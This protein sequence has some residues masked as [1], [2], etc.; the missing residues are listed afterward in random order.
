MLTSVAAAC[1]RSSWCF[2]IAS[3]LRRG[4]CCSSS[5]SRGSSP[6][7]PQSA[8]SGSRSAVAAKMSSAAAALDPSSD[9]PPPFFRVA[10]VGGG[11]AGAA[12]ASTIAAAAGANSRVTLF[13]GGR[14]SSRPLLRKALEGVAENPL[15]DHGCQFV[16]DDGSDAR[17][18]ALLREHATEWSGEEELEGGG[19]RFVSLDFETGRVRAK[20]EE[21]ARDGDGDGDFFGVLSKGSRVWVGS[22]T[23]DAIPKRLVGDS[24]SKK[25]IDVRVGWKVTAVAR[26]GAGGGEWRVSARPPP[27]PPPGQEGAAAGSAGAAP[28]DEAGPLLFDAVVLSDASAMRAGSASAV[29][30]ELSSSEG[31]GAAGGGGGGGGALPSSPSSAPLEALARSRRAPLFSVAALLPNPLPRDSIPFDLAVVVRGKGE[32][33]DVSVLVRESA[34]PGRSGGSSGG[35]ELWVAVS[36]REAA[37][38]LLALAPPS[39]GPP[40]PEALEKAAERLWEAAS[41]ALQRAAGAAAGKEKKG[42]S[43]AV[44]SLKPLALRA[45][46]WGAGVE[47]SP[48]GN[49]LFSLDESSMLAA[50]GD[51]FGKG[52]AASALLSGVAAGEALLRAATAAEKKEKRREKNKTTSGAKL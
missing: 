50:C 28:A 29:A 16:V 43:P 41:T 19:S 6:F 31:G 21:S 5:S 2:P 45:Q 33:S 8:A 51:V 38:E 44:L 40:P 39:K 24:A 25:N 37:A 17:L 1:L 52:D 35:G 4:S 3:I 7:L 23:I 22:P 48:D 10:V 9:D 34:K 36:S 18:T 32:K 42:E 20:G 27:P 26:G 11:L 49:A 13:D 46:R 15:T 12:A 14:A 47:T 30:V